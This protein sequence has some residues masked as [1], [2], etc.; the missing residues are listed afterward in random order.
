[1]SKGHRVQFKEADGYACSY[2]HI[3][4]TVVQRDT[5]QAVSAGQIGSNVASVTPIGGHMHAMCISHTGDVVI[6][7]STKPEG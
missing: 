6:I 2:Y 7:L 3:P 5:S 1:M 4:H